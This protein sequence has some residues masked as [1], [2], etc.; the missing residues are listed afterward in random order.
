M[1]FLYVHED[2]ML[3]SDE[4]IQR[5]GEGMGEN[6]GEDG[7]IVLIYKKCHN[8]TPCATTVY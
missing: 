8:E 1:H 3:N 7:H 2:G 5:S 6:N 4:V